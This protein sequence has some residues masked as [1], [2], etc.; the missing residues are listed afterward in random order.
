MLAECGNNILGIGE[1]PFF[2]S[3]KKDINF[4]ESQKPYNHLLK[5][6]SYLISRTK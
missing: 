4:S 1:N 3:S 6:Q 5:D 2:L